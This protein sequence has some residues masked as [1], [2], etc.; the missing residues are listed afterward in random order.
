MSKTGHTHGG[1][2]YNMTTQQTKKKKTTQRT[3]KRKDFYSGD[4]ML[5]TVW[6]PSQWHFLHTM[7]FN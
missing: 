4:G 1:T 2:E 7:S 3:F 6:G 5:T